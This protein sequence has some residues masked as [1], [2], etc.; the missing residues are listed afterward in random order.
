[1]TTVHKIRINIFVIVSAQPGHVHSRS[2][3]SAVSHDLH[4]PCPA[5]EC[6][7]R[8]SARAWTRFLSLGVRP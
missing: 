7:T 2:L 4:L 5:Q 6:G 8:M 3:A 1:M